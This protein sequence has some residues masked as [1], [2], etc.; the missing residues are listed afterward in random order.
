MEIRCYRSDQR[1]LVSDRNKSF[2]QRVAP[3]FGGERYEI[4]PPS[5]SP[6]ERQRRRLAFRNERKFYHRKCDRSGK[7]VISVSLIAV[8]I[9]LYFFGDR[10]API[11]RKFWRRHGLLFCVWV[12]GME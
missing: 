8:L 10:I 12:V 11:V 9:V 5:L 3:Q 6:S 1:F 2:Y 7:Q 4:P